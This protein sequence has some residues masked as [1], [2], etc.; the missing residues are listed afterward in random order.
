MRAPTSVLTLSAAMLLGSG[1]LLAQSNAPSD[2]TATPSA[3][4]DTA[5][6]PAPAAPTTAAPTAI[7]TVPTIEIQHLRPV[8]QRG[9]NVFETPKHDS[10]PYTGF[11]LGWGA[12]FTQQFQRL[13]HSNSAVPVTKQNATGQDYNANELMGI[14]SGFNNAVANLYQNAQLAPGIRV[15]MT[16][17]LSARHH[18]ETWV[19]DGYLLI[20]QSPI[21]VA[22]LENVMKYVTVKAGHFEINYGDA[23]FRR[24][25]NG[26]AMYNPLVGN[27]IMDAFTTQIGGEVYVRTGPWMVMGGVTGGEV[28]GQ[29]TAPEKRSLAYLGKAGFDQQ[30]TDDLRVRLTGSMFSQAR[31]ANN[32]LYTGDRAGSRYYMVMENTTATEKDQAWSGAIQPGF[33]S[34][35]HAFVVNPFLKYRDVEF[36]G[37]FEQAKGRAATEPANRKWTQNSYELTYR[38]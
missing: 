31:S 23:H 27:Y 19:K 13:D 28:R 5:A 34:E 18:Q 20:D 1:P 10:V 7:S 4:A 38:L 35:T 37:N 11:K 22:L 26:N 9:V 33:R 12:A 17:Y 14:G 30:V 8:D 24:T 25:D 16:T 2:T 21:K 3:A 32:T 15:A 29:V 6:A 36:F